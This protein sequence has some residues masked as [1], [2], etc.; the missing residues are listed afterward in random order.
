MPKTGNQALGHWQFFRH[1]MQPIAPAGVVYQVQRSP[2]FHPPMMGTSIQAGMSDLVSAVIPTGSSGR[3]TCKTI[4]KLNTTSVAS[5]LVVSTS[6]SEFAES[7]QIK[8][9]E[10]YAPST[11]AALLRVW[12]NGRPLPL[13]INK[14]LILHQFPCWA[15]SCMYIPK[16]VLRVWHLATFVRYLVAKHAGFPYLH[17]HCRKQWPKPTQWLLILVHVVRLLRFLCHSS[18]GWSRA[19]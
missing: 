14:A 16:Q 17:R 13:A 5:S 10:H 6:K 7:H 19:F 11:L 12:V 3:H 15:I 18:S 8:A 9:V 2:T 1:G 4:S